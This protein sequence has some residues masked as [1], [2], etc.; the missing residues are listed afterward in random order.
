M[1]EPRRVVVTGIGVVTPIG[2]GIDDAWAAATDGRSGAGPV[3][4]F[5]PDGFD[6]RI[7]CEV[8]G[9][10]ARDYMERRDARRSDRFCRY[11]VA[12]AVMAAEAAGWDGL[13]YPSERVGVIVGSGVGGLETLETQHDVLRDRGVSKLSP[14]TIPLLMINGAAG[15]IG[16]R[17]GARGPNWSPVSAC[18]TGGHSIGEAMRLIRSG[19]VEAAFCGGAE[20]SITPLAMGAFAAMGALSR[21]NDDPATASRPF[22]ADRDGFV[23]GEGAGVLVLESLEGAERRGAP[24]LCEVAGYGASGDAYHLTQPDPEG[25]GAVG[26]MRTALGDAGVDP[27]EVGYVNAHGTSTPFNDRVESGAIRKVFGPEPPPVSSTK[28]VTGHLLGAAGAVEAA[29]TAMALRDGVLPP[30]ANHET[31]DPDCGI[32]PVPNTAREASVDVALSN[33][34]GFGGHNACIV[35]RRPA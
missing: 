11:A 2:V 22:D 27:S 21:R 24:I 18:A 6:V 26:A 33:A 28:S 29:F 12:S 13:P 25:E 14:F 30:T 15:S 5:D 19:E 7:A 9:F 31:P 3:T 32:D 4:R 34:F 35:L 23:M 20:A 17:F 16:M 1:T 10:D 8:D